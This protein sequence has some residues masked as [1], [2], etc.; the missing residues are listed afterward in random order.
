MTTTT[1][2]PHLYSSVLEAVLADAIETGNPVLSSELYLNRPFVLTD[3]GYFWGRYA[4]YGN[5]GPQPQAYRTAS[6]MELA[7]FFCSLLFEQ[8]PE[9][10][11]GFKSECMALTAYYR[12]AA[13]VGTALAAV[14]DA[15][16]HLHHIQDA[17]FS[18]LG[19]QGGAHVA[20]VCDNENNEYQAWFDEQLVLT[21]VS[22]LKVGAK[23]VWPAVC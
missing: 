9:S 1:T 12:G 17:T 22:D 18:Y 5:R 21:H 10:V 20:C 19:Y 4:V 7:A 8:Q 16:T 13:P 14:F 3:D 15:A 23:Q 6:A 2:Q 11:S